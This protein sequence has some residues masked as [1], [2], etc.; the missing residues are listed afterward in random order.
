MKFFNDRT[1]F[2]ISSDVT[3]CRKKKRKKKIENRVTLSVQRQ[4]KTSEVLIKFPAVVKIGKIKCFRRDGQI[5][6]LKFFLS[7]LEVR[8]LKKS[9]LAENDQNQGCHD[10]M[11]CASL[12]KTHTRIL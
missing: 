12:K 9:K 5:L 1:E 4:M 8:F 10:L 6:V 2:L 7:L 3:R 11:S